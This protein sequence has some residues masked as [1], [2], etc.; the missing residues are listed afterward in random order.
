M[1]KKQSSDEPSE[2]RWGILTNLL[3]SI[4]NRLV[5]VLDGLK[6]PAEIEEGK[7]DPMQEALE[8]LAHAVG[9]QNARLEAIERHIETL[10][11]QLQDIADAA[12]RLG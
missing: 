8:N 5:I 3:R 6:I 11:Q 4:N 1:K 7:L 9:E 2:G 10:T 12:R